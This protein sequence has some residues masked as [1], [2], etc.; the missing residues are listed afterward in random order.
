M[1]EWQYFGWVKMVTGMF[2]V[3]VGGHFSW[4]DEGM[5]WYIRVRRRF[6]I[7]NPELN[8]EAVF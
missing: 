6:K 1:G 2:W 5:F 3:R 7:K 8:L 4:V